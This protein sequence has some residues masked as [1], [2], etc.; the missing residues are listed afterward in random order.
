MQKGSKFVVIAD[1][2]TGLDW[3]QHLHETMASCS[4]MKQAYNIGLH[5]AR[6]ETPSLN[7]RKAMF[8]LNLTGACAI[9]E[10]DRGFVIV[11]VKN[12]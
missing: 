6:I 4:N 11:K 3:G 10:G 8:I 2:E 5:L 9:K 7:Y 12:Y 1:R